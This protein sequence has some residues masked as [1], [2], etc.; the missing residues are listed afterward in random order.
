[1]PRLLREHSPLIEEFFA[2]SRLALP[3]VFT[4][5]GLVAMGLI[6]TLIVGQVGPASLAGVGAGSGVFFTIGIVGMGILGSLDTFVSQAFGAKEERVCDNLLI[7]GIWLAL[8]LGLL[9]LPV[10]WVVGRFYGLTG[11]TTDIVLAASPYIQTVSWSLPVFLLFIALQKY[12]QALGVVMPATYIV[13]VANVVN[14]FGA[15]ALARGLWGAPA[16]GAKGVAVATVGTRVFMAIALVGYTC[17]RLRRRQQKEAGRRLLWGQFRFSWRVQRQ[18]LRLGLPAGA[19]SG[20]EVLAFTLTTILATRLG[21]GAAAAHHIVLTIASTTFMMP[22]GIG[23]AGAVRVGNLVGAGAHRAATR[24]GWM[25]IGLGVLVMTMS[26]VVLCAFPTFLFGLF[27]ND[28]VVLV[29]GQKIMI[30][31]ALFQ[32]FDGTQVTSTFALRG[33]GDTRSA[34]IANIIGHYPIGLLLG[35]SLCFLQDRGLPG[36]WAGLT[37]GLITVATLTVLSWRQKARALVLTAERSLT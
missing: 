14:F 26:A 10:I 20:A 25:A 8:L 18:L 2:T 30:F 9:L 22:L 17:W 37:F 29:Q 32:I 4:N 21:A 3:V 35:F 31:A 27:T 33:L 34:M 15:T 16:M 13:F 28:A 12:W 5:I 1:M 24:A 11:A 6:D 36:L 23:N 7:Q 19:Q